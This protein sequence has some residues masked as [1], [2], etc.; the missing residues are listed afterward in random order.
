LNI[1]FDRKS[2]KFKI[3]G[4]FI[5]LAVVILTILWFLQVLF[6]NTYYQGMKIRQVERIGNE[7]AL[8]YNASGFLTRM[9]SITYHNDLQIRIETIDGE[10]IFS[11]DELPFRG[12]FKDMPPRNFS[13]GDLRAKLA[14]SQ[15]GTI[16]L[17]T[18]SPPMNSDVLVYGKLLPDVGAPQAYLFIISPLSPVESTIGI[19]K[20]QL[21]R[22]SIISLLLAFLI[23]LLI[24][25]RIT[26]PILDIAKEAE[27]LANGIYD[28]NFKTGNFS[29]ID[30]LAGT[31][32][33]TAG[34]L[35][36]TDLLQKDLI[37]NVSHDLRTP[38]TLVKSYAEMIKDLSGEDPARRKEHLQVII[39]EADRLS[40]LVDDLL[41]LAKIQSGVESLKLERFNVRAMLER[42][43][44]PYHILQEKENGR[45]T[46]SC[47]D[48]ITLFADERRIEQV[49][50]NLVSNAFKFSADPKSIR[51]GVAYTTSGFLRFEISDNGK[52][53][54]DDEL[55]YIWDRYY[56]TSR[57][58]QRESSGSGLG[59][60]IVREILE[61]HKA[62]YGVISTV[63]SGSVFWFELNNDAG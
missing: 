30:K 20:S 38:L 53:I 56:K 34:E 44:Q 58:H 7:I 21:I 39:D 8:D 50:S 18:K 61:L 14:E 31:L 19:L 40:L 52:G 28:V 62:K 4:Y 11:T 23:A 42:I 3:W 46:V 57:Q 1:N 47:D 6:L 32:N 54:P 59:L 13:I 41:V 12:P 55:D 45:L 33:H 15:S 49:L 10:L 9:E 37:A 29:E 63:G 36:K 24:S 43:L 5:L 16:S 22:V 60:A 48:E 26:K 2:L 27:K 25:R 51:I 35:A 17:I